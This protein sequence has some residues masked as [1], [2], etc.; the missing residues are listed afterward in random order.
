[1]SRS[2][3][4]DRRISLVLAVVALLA[5]ACGSTTTL[6]ANLGGSTTREDASRNS[7]GLPAPELSNEERR[8]F[9]IGDSFFTQNWVTAPA[10]TDAR[11][12]LGPTF[13]AQACSSCHVLD[14]RG[15]PPDVTGNE[16]RLGLLLRLSVP[17]SDPVTGAPLPDPTYGGQLQDRGVLGVEPEGTID[18]TYETIAGTYDDGEQYELRAPTYEITDLAF[19][20]LAD[21]VMISPRLAPQVIG[22]GLLEAIPADRIQAAA[23]PDDLDDDGISGRPNSVWN[24]RTQSMDIGRFGWKANVATVEQQVA[25]AFHGDIGITSSLHPDEN[26]PEPQ[27]ACVTAPSGTNPGD[28]DQG[29]L[30]DSRLGSV[31]FYNRTLSVPA[32]RGSDLDEVRA[33]SELFTE[34]GCSSCHTPTQQ[35]GDADIE[36]LANQTIHPYTDLLLHDMGPDLADGRPDFDAS[37][38]EW[39]TPPLWGL[40]LIDDVNGERFLLH[41]GRARTIPEA[42]LWHGGE[43]AT[44]AERFRSANANDRNALVEFLEAL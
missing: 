15:F 10:S 34:F 44:S 33:G 19:G 14:G 23:D 16:A 3:S 1:M 27:T 39:R 38:T 13:N 18:L 7:F 6:D 5:T 20:P 11:D 8:A 32:M 40:G 30:T 43:G 35:T 29:E 21:D 25:G 28:D 9:E 41:D 2:T 22:M 24:G 4:P 26:C 12:G 37:G 17:G 31:T 36:T 42:I